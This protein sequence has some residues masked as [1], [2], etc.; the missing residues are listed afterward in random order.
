MSFLD[1]K[2]LYTNIPNYEAIKAAK[3]ALNSVR[4]K[5]VATKFII[6]FLF[7]ILTSNNFIFN[8]IHYHQKLGS[9]MGT[10]CAPN[11]ANIPCLQTFSTF[12][13]VD[14]SM[15]SFYSGMEAINSRHPTI[16]FDFKYSK[17]STKFLDTKICKNKEKNKLLTTIYWKPTDR[18]NFLDPTSAHPK[19]LIN[20]IPFSQALQLKKI[21]SETPE[22][23]K[24]L[25]ELKESSINRDYK[26]HFLT[27]FVI[28]NP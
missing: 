24:H 26:E 21:C 10:I 6:R 27:Q 3:E 13:I 2:S 15:L 19:P 1:V 28:F 18:R 9:A 11:Y 17:S 7:L 23:N 4:K 20:S 8:I 12:F 5:P 22:L 25:N 16:K 14:L